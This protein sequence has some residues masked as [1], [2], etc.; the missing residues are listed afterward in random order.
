MVP[1]T[2][3][4]PLRVAIIGSGPSAFYVAEFLQKQEQFALEIDMFERLPTP[5]GLVRGGVAPD[6]PKIKAVTKVYD[7]TASHPNFRFYG[8]VLFGR[9]LT[10]ADLAFHYHLIVYAVGA[11]TDRSMGI[12]GEDLPGSHAAT[13]F[14]GWYNGHPDY[15]E[16]CFDLSQERIAVVGN[17]NVAMDVVRILSRTYNELRSTDIAD[18]ALKAI[19]QSRVREIY[20]LGRRGPI[21]AQFTNSEIKELGELADATIV[22]EPDEIELDPLSCDYLLNS[23]DRTAEHNY[24]TL[25]AYA[26]NGTNGKR[27]KIV[28]RFLVS[29]DE[30]IGGERVEAIKLVKN[31]LYRREDGSLRPRPTDQCEI[32]PVGLVFRSIGYQ[33]VPLPGVPFDPSRGVIANIQGRVINANGQ[34]RLGEYV[35]GWIKRGP[36]GIIGTNK[37][38]AQ[39][40]TTRLLE[41]VARGRFLNPLQP[42]RQAVEDRLHERGIRYVSY[43]D[44]RQLDQMEIER[45][46][47]VG[48]PRIKFTRVDRML[49]AL[50][51]HKRE[52]ARVLGH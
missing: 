33:G 49:A 42:S 28:L 11:Q 3:K 40:T 35:V 20:V 34:Q 26:Q 44:W 7:K 29:P 12:P 13:E 8:N 4:N 5:F 14:I 27:R 41:D 10:Y 19:S 17:G 23:N 30:I 1:G 16:R 45:G 36:T 25:K 51:Q 38:D 52:V 9:D 18:Y 43:D 2:P 46:S 37:P 15:R 22:V 32:L 48:R 6:H 31:E 47:A 24:Q 21:Q 50:D 39:E